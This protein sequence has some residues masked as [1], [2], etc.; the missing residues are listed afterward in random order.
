MAGS[1]RQNCSMD[2]KGIP[3][4]QV[5]YRGKVLEEFDI[6]A[7]IARKPKIII[8]DELAHT[9]VPGSRHPK[10]YQDIQ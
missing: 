4:K 6:D 1:R 10:R 3:R 9:N 2:L 8:V 5:N 7:A